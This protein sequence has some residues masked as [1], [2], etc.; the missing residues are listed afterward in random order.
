M[1]IKK[2]FKIKFENP[3]NA[4]KIGFFQVIKK[5][6]VY[7]NSLLKKYLIPV[8]LAK[9]VWYYEVVKKLTIKTDLII[10]VIKH[11]KKERGRKHEK[12]K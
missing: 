3:K 9:T 2:P 11:I 1:Y 12:R 10:W 7:I 6:T 5:V 8:A 4:Y